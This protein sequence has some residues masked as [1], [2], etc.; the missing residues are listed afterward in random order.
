MHLFHLLLGFLTVT[1]FSILACGEHTNKQKQEPVSEMLTNEEKNTYWE[2][3]LR[4][5]PHVFTDTVLLDQAIANYL[6]YIESKDS[7]TI[8][9]SL[10]RIAD[11]LPVDS[12]LYFLWDRLDHYVYHPN[13]PMRNDEHS[14]LLFEA[15]LK[16]PAINDMYAVKYGHIVNML[17][18]NRVGA[19]AA[20]FEYSNDKGNKQELSGI[21]V[22]FLLLIF[23]DPSCHTCSAMLEQLKGA[24]LMNTWIKEGK[25]GVL[26][27]DVF[28]DAV[29]YE[30]HKSVLSP[31]W[32]NGIDLDQ[33]ILQEHKYN[34]LAY[35]TIYVLDRDKK[36]L[37]K[38]VSIAEAA[39]FVQQKIGL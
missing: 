30:K 24:S 13:S 31:L 9:H 34:L 26:T 4:K 1:I 5:E 2:E 16:F 7:S 6:A 37:L 15:L 19:T 33:R 17:H 21:D 11:L 23:Y 14:L 27:V 32:T 29:Q 10:Q 3:L 28:G 12:A 20:N 22:P 18:K 35:P 8:V 38:D 25:L 36:V 39:S